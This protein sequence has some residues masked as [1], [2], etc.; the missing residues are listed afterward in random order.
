MKSTESGSPEEAARTANTPAAECGTNRTDPAAASAPGNRRHP[1]QHPHPTHPKRKARAEKR[2]RHPLHRPTPH[3]AARRRA[4]AHRCAMG[5][6]SGA[7]P[8]RAGSNTTA[9]GAYA[10]IQCRRMST[11]RTVERRS[12]ACTATAADSMR[13]IRSNPSGN[14]SNNIS[15]TSTSSTARCGRPSGSFSAARAC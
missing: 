11:A 12:G 15:R 1:G 6:S 4:P 10:A 2:C 7:G 8:W 14:T 13:S 5:S 9:C 3:P